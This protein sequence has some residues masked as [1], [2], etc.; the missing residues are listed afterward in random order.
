MGTGR[1]PMSSG[2]EVGNKTEIQDNSDLNVVE[3]RYI[4]CIIGTNQERKF[5]SPGIGA[6]ADTVYSI[7]YQDIA[8]VISPSPIMKYPISRENTMAHQKVLEELIGDFTVLPVKF[9]TVASGK[10][11]VCAEERIREEVLKARYEELKGLLT[12]MDNK[13]ELGLKALWSDMRVIFKEIVEENRDIKI[14]K[15]TIASRSSLQ[16]YGDRIALGEKVKDALERKKAKEQKDILNVLKEAY[17][18]MRSNKIFGDNMITNLAFLVEKPRAE[19][20]DRLVDRLSTIYD[21]RIKFKY[22]GPVPPC[23]FVELVI[24]LEGESYEGKA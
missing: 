17:V 7:P 16:T 6:R 11:G 10:D 20:F 21:G 8:A 12:K 14:L 4:Y 13:I 24:V 1:K 2:Q 22:V 5:T 9:G 3:G 23:N 15:K 19:E 18:D